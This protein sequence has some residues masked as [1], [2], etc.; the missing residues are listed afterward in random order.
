MCDTVS[1]APQVMTLKSTGKTP[2]IAARPPQRNEEDQDQAIAACCIALFAGFA[3]HASA[4]EKQTLRLVQ[5]I[6]FRA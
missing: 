2:G 3:V 1:E 6:R 4:Q 5:T